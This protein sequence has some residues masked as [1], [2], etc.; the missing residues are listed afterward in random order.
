MYGAIIGDVIGSP[1]EHHNIKTKDF[2]LFS[3]Q[4]RLTDD[5]VMTIAV[6]E[7]IMNYFDFDNGSE[8]LM[9]QENQDLLKDRFYIG[10]R[11]WGLK[12][13]N[14]GYGGSFRR[15]L[16]E[17]GEPYNSWG[18]GSAM[19]VS[20]VA[21]LFDDIEN[22]RK[23]AAISA[24]VTHN[25][26]EGIKGAECIASA[27]FL[28]RDGWLK[29]DISDYIIREFGYDISRTCDDIRPSYSFDVSCQGSVPQ[30]I[31]AFMDGISFE[32]VVRNAVSLGGDSDTI[33]AM[34][35]SIAHAYYGVPSDLRRSIE[36]ML[37]V[38]QLRVLERYYDCGCKRTVKGNIT[39]RIRPFAYKYLPPQDQEI[40]KYYAESLDI[41]KTAEAFNEDIDRI[42]KIAELLKEYS[43]GIHH[44][45]VRPL[46]DYLE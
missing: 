22:V 30:A 19:R 5:S 36:A 31:I 2:P 29:K 41:Y 18:N 43:R 23:A 45:R 24:S 42:I 20:S 1:Y 34:A 37:T 32:D 44:T 12:Y 11:K 16:S 33:A 39:G 6:A 40:A 4:S 21:W 3:D 26:P 38:E 15:W 35:G 25:H 10:L 14:A 27:V 13:P 8:D 46:R 28:A 17:G 7:A 9:P